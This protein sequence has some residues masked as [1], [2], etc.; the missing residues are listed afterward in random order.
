MSEPV[1]VARGLEAEGSS[2]PIFGPLDLELRPGQVCLVRGEKGSG[3]SALLLALAARFRPARGELI[4]NGIDAIAEPRQAMK[5]AGVAQIGNYVMPEDRLTLAE[6]IA[7]RCYLDGVALRDGE[8]RVAQLE[9]LAGF[10]IDKSVELEDLTALERAAASVALTML[11]PTKV[12]VIDDA[13]LMVP[14]AQQQ[15]MFDVFETLAELDGATIVAS[16]VDNDTAP[17][18]AVLVEL[19]RHRPNAA[20]RIDQRVRVVHPAARHA[21]LLHSDLEDDSLLDLALLDDAI[22]ASQYD[23]GSPPQAADDAEQLADDDAGDAS[24]PLDEGGDE[25]PERIADGEGPADL[26]GPAEVHEVSGA[27][28]EGPVDA[29]LEGAAPDEPTA[30]AD[31]ENEER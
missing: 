26:A 29:A 24:D 11:R 19:A 8:E 22:V 6:S 3:K 12:V 18:T 16:T 9:R 20:R 2:G 13:D 30:D 10:T 4:I 21:D 31:R 25:R 7:E 1:L 5:W 23:L 17:P 14:H 15:F 27:A 28:D